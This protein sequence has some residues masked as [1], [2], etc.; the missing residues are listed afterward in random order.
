MILNQAPSQDIADLIARC[1]LRDHAA[2]RSLYERTSAK[3]FGIILRILKDR[4][5]AEE[6]MQDVYVKIWQRA[7]RYVAGTTSP[8]SYL[9]AVARNYSLDLL[10]ARRPMADNIDVATA[11]RAGPA[12][13]LSSMVPSAPMSTNPCS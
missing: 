2:F 3:L 11:A 8:I 4:S 7:D 12:F 13:I 1:A 10:R 5:E 6:A 9:V